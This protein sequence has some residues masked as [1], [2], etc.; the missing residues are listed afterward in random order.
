LYFI[1]N[2][3]LKPR[4]VWLLCSCCSLRLFQDLPSQAD[5]WGLL[6]QGQGEFLE[7]EELFKRVL[8]GT[9]GFGRVGREA[10]H[11]TT[12]TILH[13]YCYFIAI[14][15]ILYL[16]L[17]MYIYTIFWSFLVFRMDTVEVEDLASRFTVWSLSWQ[18]HE[19]LLGSS[20]PETMNTLGILSELLQDQMTRSAKF[21]CA[22]QPPSWWWRVVLRKRSS[23]SFSMW[24]TFQQ[25][26]YVI[27]S[28]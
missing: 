23:A 22:N 28:S 18:G 15:I 21:L 27:C 12:H 3:G 16:C 6:L 1:V 9:R 14:Y 17:F 25:I 5:I 10:L 19:E 2:L 8:R 11:A 7:A 4:H 26:D 24:S 13:N 20:H